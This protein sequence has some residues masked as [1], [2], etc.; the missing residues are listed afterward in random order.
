[1]LEGY[2]LRKVKFVPPTTKGPGFPEPCHAQNLHQR[3]SYQPASRLPSRSANLEKAQEA[4]RGNTPTGGVAPKRVA[5]PLE[6]VQESLEERH[7]ILEIGNGYP[8][9]GR[10]GLLD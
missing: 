3:F 2:E 1:M 7:A 8:F 5:R 6:T 9:I 4:D 10:M